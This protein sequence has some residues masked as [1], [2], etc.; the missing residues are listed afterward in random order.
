MAPAGQKAAEELVVTA[1]SWRTL[2]WMS[3]YA[4]L[5]RLLPS[6]SG[7]IYSG[8]CELFEL[9]FLHVFHCFSNVSIAELLSG[10][11]RQVPPSQRASSLLSENEPNP[12]D[13]PAGPSKA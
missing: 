9:Y 4:D 10:H 12:L 13:N 3:H 2:Q 6:D 5:M 7:K 11:S 8:C 1:A